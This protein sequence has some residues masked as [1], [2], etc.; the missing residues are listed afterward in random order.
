[1]KI[2]LNWIKNYLPDLKIEDENVF[3]SD[4]VELGFDIESVTDQ[5]GE[6]KNFIVGEVIEKEKHPDADKL[7]VCKVNTGEKIFNVVCGAPNVDVGQ[8]ICFAQ[9]GAI[10]PNG[11]FEIKKSKIRGVLSEGMICSESE[12]KLSD[13]H[14]GIMVLNSEAII[15][16]PIADYLNKNDKVFDIWVPPNR[17]DLSSHIGMAREIAARY[18]LKLNIPE[19]KESDYTENIGKTENLIKIQ[20][21]DI[22]ACKRFTG[23]VIKN[24]SVVE[25]PDWLKSKITA[26]GLRPVNNIVD[27]T[28]YVMFETGQPLHAFD[29][30]KINGK[31]ITVKFSNSGDKFT[32]LDSKERLLPE[33]T[34]MICDD[35]GYTGIAGIM[36]GENSEIT[37]DTKNV[38]LEVAYFEPVTVRLA[39]KKLGII[40]DASQRFEKGVD[41]SNIPYVSK[42]ATELIKEIAGGEVSDN[43]YDEYVNKPEPVSVGV[44][45]SF[46]SK[47]IG[48]EFTEE[49]IIQLLGLLQIE[50]SGK[51]KDYL[52]FNIPEWR[53]YDISNEYDLIEE[54]LRLNGFNKI[55]MLSS[56]YLS[57]SEKDKYTKEYLKTIELKK[58]LTGRGYNEILTQ[59]IQGSANYE[60]FGDKLIQIKNP[61]S[62]ELNII[63]SNLI[64]GLLKVIKNNVNHIGKDISLKLYEIGKVFKSEDGIYKENNE[65]AFAL[66]GNDDKK[67]HNLNNSKF[68]IFNLKG[69]VEMLLAKMN[70]EN[71]KLFYYND[72]AYSSNFI[73]VSV[74][75]KNKNDK[76]DVIGKIFKIS[77][78]VLEKFDIESDVFIA[79]FDLDKIYNYSKPNNRY[80]EITKFPSVKR[81]LAVVTDKKINF[82]EISKYLNNKIAKNLSKAELFDIYE[83][84]KLGENKKSFAF[85]L[86]FISKEK[87]LSDEEVN[88]QIN[89]IVE[90]LRK[91]T[92]AVLRK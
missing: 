77:Q 59:T 46:A 89:N 73:E 33:N 86:E 14:D 19:V 90:K 11:N 41:I 43:L 24:V 64:I 80:E 53:R 20:I 40:T 61:Q 15:G 56:L 38:F 37:K 26:I 76:P 71:I 60:I 69:E 51:D 1:M 63:R 47:I 66:Y 88:T 48:I 68:S 83:D 81:D 36:G 32:T 8:K 49:K 85:S 45:S 25:S 67:T 23:R 34:L 87:T 31:K 92:G 39:A 52:I 12:L 3:I 70:I 2:S 29:Y 65:I 82:E 74:S 44:R 5:A 10:V 84:G 42:R 55:P 21:D 9:I 75:T 27:I 17:G 54:V 13:N 58:Y 91:E 50:Y 28:N 16:T 18:N 6:L 35:L 7:S 72:L 78:D 30:D 57:L 4:L 62:S 79:S 22:N